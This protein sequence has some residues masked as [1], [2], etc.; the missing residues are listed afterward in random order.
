[1]NAIF[2]KPPKFLAV[3]SNLENMRR[4]F[5]ANRLVV[6]RYCDLDM[7]HDRIQGRLGGKKKVPLGAIPRAILPA[8]F[9]SEV[10]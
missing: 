6:R 7:P 3:Y 5:S 4:F 1:M 9:T 10:G 2:K 8:V